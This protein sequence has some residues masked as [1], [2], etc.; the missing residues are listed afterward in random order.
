MNAKKVTRK[1]YYLEQNVSLVSMIEY[2]ENAL[3]CV[4]DCEPVEMNYVEVSIFC[5]E[6][7]VALVEKAVA[8]LI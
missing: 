1:V 8:P 3:G 4:V 2:L 7:E 5:Y 6:D